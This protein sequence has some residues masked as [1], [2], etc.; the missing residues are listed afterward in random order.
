MKYAPFLKTSRGF[1]TF[2]LQSIGN[3]VG[4]RLVLVRR[5]FEQGYS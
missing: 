5:P 2:A 4:D 1:S 3:R